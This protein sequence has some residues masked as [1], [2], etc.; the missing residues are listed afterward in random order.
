[1]KD[2]LAS[3]LTQH[4]ADFRLL[5]QKVVANLRNFPE[6]ARFLRGLVSIIG[7]NRTIIEYNETP[8]KNGTT[9]YSLSK[10]MQLGRHGVLSFTV[11]PLRI[12][13]YLGLIISALCILYALWITFYALVYKVPAGISSILVGIFFI[14]GIQLICLGILGEY[15][16]NISMEV[17]R[18]PLYIIK[19]KATS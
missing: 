8:R 16:A 19:E 10:M 2:V 3:N 18:R 5:D 15:I 1:M 11:Q 7:F 14:G 12:S 9:K 6:Q 4:N 17:K 13:T